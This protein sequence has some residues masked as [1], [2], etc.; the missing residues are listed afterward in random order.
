M[1]KNKQYINTAPMP[2]NLVQVIEY[3]RSAAVKAHAPTLAHETGVDIQA[4]YMFRR[5]ATT[6]P[7]PEMLD[8]L[9]EYFLPNAQ[10][11]VPAREG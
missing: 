3:L 1:T 5:G 10:I 4:I 2:L 9:I 11:V 8:A 6:W 7:K